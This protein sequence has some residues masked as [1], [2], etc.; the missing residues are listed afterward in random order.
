MIHVAADDLSVFRQIGHT[1]RLLRAQTQGHILA[2]DEEKH[3][4][5]GLTGTM[6]CWAVVLDNLRAPGPPFPVNPPITWPKPAGVLCTL[7][8]PIDRFRSLFFHAV[9]L[10]GR[11]AKNWHIN[12]PTIRPRQ[13]QQ[14]KT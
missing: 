5:V 7:S 9:I 2:R 13:S 8:V 4:P 6:R 3:H 10:P 1:G 14:A 12:W 11:G